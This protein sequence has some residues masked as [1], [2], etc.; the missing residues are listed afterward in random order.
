M[1]GN[2]RLTGHC[3]KGRRHKMISHLYINFQHW[4]EEGRIWLYSDPH[5]GDAEAADFRKYHISDEDQIKRINSK[6]GKKDAIVFLGDIGNIECIKKIKGY[7][8]L[9]K[10][11]HDCGSSKYLK[12][13][14]FTYKNGDKIERVPKD[15]ENWALEQLING[16]GKVR[17][18]DTGLFDEV[19]DGP[20]TISSKIILSHEPLGINNMLNIHGHDHSEWYKADNAINCCAELIDYT[21]ISLDDIVKSG[22]LN[23]IPDVHR[24]VIDACK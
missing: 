2:T 10:G 12:E 1:H 6:V 7:K 20:L 11:N 16:D 21:P 14:Y 18:K 23:K 8:I 4:G 5:F 17:V 19:Y 24:N 3:Q 13:L 15:K 22:R 9:I